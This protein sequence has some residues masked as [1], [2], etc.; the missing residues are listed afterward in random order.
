M[1]KFTAKNNNLHIILKYYMSRKIIRHTLL[2]LKVI[3]KSHFCTKVSVVLV[4]QI[5][6]CSSIV[7]TSYRSGSTGYDCP[8]RNICRCI[9]SLRHVVCPIPSQHGPWST[10][11][12][13]WFLRQRSLIGGLCVTIKRSSAQRWR[14]V[15]SQTDVSGVRATSTT[16]S[17]QIGIHRRT[18]LVHECN[19]NRV[20]DCV[21]FVRCVV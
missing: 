5:R 2:S 21:E 12:S 11:P 14:N 19:M 15:P 13:A 7:Y 8:R 6:Q 18:N 20:Q 3:K 4:A 17:G 16:S 10:D 1:L 9:C